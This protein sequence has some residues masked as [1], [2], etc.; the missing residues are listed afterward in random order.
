MRSE[1]FLS[2]EGVFEACPIC[3]AKVHTLASCP[4][5][6]APC[7]ELVVAKMEASNLEHESSVGD[8]WATILPKRRGKPRLPAKAQKSKAYF[9][10]YQA[11][12]S[13]KVVGS[14]L[15]SPPVQFTHAVPN[16][17]IFNSFAP[18]ADFQISSGEKVSLFPPSTEGIEEDKGLDES[19]INEAFLNALGV[20]HQNPNINLTLK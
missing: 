7:V 19:E 8:D 20:M 2:Y 1:F 10:P 4:T 13:S 5:K 16:V 9:S 6:P 14:K 12:S 15:S 11:P 18:I 3:W 17:D